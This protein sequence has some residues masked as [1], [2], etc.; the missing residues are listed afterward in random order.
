VVAI[1]IVVAV[2]I[3]VTYERAV[4]DNAFSDLVVD[5]DLTRLGDNMRMAEYANILST[6]EEFL[7]KTIRVSGLYFTIVDPVSWRLTNIV[8]IT[9]PD[10]CCP[11][12]GFEV[13]VGSFDNPLPFDF[14]LEGRRIELA[15]VFSSYNVEG[16]DFYY[17]AVD[18]IVILR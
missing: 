5:V 2:I 9:E 8:T 15:G 17:L 6:P 14:P 10:S 3:N 4:I 18:D 1:V 12:E 16:F 7:G 11:P 13:I